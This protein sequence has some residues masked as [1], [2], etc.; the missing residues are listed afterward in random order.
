MIIEFTGIPC[1]GKSDISHRLGALLYRGG[2]SV[3]QEQYILSHRCSKSKRIFLKLLTAI[4]ECIRHPYRSY[5]ALSYIN[6]KTVW[7][8]Y[9]Y[10]A[11]FRSKCDYVIFEQGICQCICS[12]FEGNAHQVDSVANLVDNLLPQ[13][14]DRLFVFVDVSPETVERRAQLRAENDR[15]FYVSSRE[16][17]H[18]VEMAIAV[19]GLLKRILQN[20]Y[21]NEQVVSV[22]NDAENK[23]QDATEL[24]LNH[25]KS[26]I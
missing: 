23:S 7:F 18:A 6:D 14:P 11:G 15:P 3:A 16:D 22:N 9:L 10:V 24:I 20:R 8:N 25:I 12:M 5:R 17:H 4:Q 2:A 13:N 1:S 26:R 19:T 21:G